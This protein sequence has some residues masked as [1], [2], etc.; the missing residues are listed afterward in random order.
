MKERLI[1]G[2]FVVIA[3]LVTL[4]SGG[5]VTACCLAMI[6]IIA[7]FEFHKVYGLQKTPFF[8][9]S[10]IGTVLIYVSLYFSK[11]FVLPI[12]IILALL[13]IAIYVVKYP[14]Y[15]DG[16]IQAAIFAFIY[17]GGNNE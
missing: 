14:K 9:I 1:G 16:K 13:E 8:Y 11:D 17:I 5:V 12:T 7:C 6:S 4:L 10:V 2:F 3:T 15:N